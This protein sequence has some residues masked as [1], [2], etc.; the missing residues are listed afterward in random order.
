MAAVPLFQQ[1]VTWTDQMSKNGRFGE[2]RAEGQ[3]RRQDCI[4]S[5]E[6]VELVFRLLRV[7]YFGGFYPFPSNTLVRSPIMRCCVVG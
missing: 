2:E 5:S 7:L 1:T 6:A 4:R 3:E